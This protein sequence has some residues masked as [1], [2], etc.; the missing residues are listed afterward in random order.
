M[1]L[2]ITGISGMRNRGVEALVVPTIQQLCQRQSDIEINILTQSPDYDLH[3]LQHH[4]V[5]I[6][7]ESNITSRKERL[8]AKI[9]PFYRTPSL[10]S[11]SSAMIASGGDVF[12]PEYPISNHLLPLKVAQKAG[13]PVIFHAQ[14]ISPYKSVE[15]AK[16]WL[17]VSKRAK[18]ITVREKATYKYITGELGLSTDLVKLVADPAFLLPPS[19]HEKVDNMLE[20]YRIYKER[21]LVAIAVSQGICGFGKGWD[22]DTHFECWQKVMTTILEDLHADIL[23]IPHVQEVWAENDDRILATNLLRAFNYDPRIHIAGADHTASEFKGLIAACDL[24]IAERMHAAI[25]GLSSG[26]CT[27]AIGYSIKAEGIMYDVVGTEIV[28]QG[29]LIPMQDFLNHNHICQAVQSIWPKRQEIAKH[30][31]EQLPKVK[32]KASENFDLILEALR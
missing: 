29:L 11:Q 31:E 23:I 15:Q 3:R 25:A 13:V 27:I 20:V 16:S 32:S 4:K 7:S 12:S 8:M 24:V 5:K 28:K 1:N 9:I 6:E 26:I 2:V 10:I 30:I 22:Y 19:P 21:P 18:L 14:S 17:E